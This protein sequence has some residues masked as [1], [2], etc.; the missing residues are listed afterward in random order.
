[1]FLAMGDSEAQQDRNYKRLGFYN[2]IPDRQ[3]CAG[4]YQADAME[5][6][7]LL[8]ALRKRSDQPG[9]ERETT[10]LSLQGLP[11]ALLRHDQAAFYLAN[12]S[13][14][15]HLCAVYL[16][17]VAKKSISSCQMAR[18]LGCTQRTTW[19]LA[20]QIREMWLNKSGTS[21][22]MAGEVDV[23][24]TYIGE[25]EKNKHASK[26]LRAGHGIFGKQPIIGMRERRSGRI[27][28]H[29]I[30][31]TGAAHLQG[32]LPSEVRL[33]SM[34]YMDDHKDCHEK[35][36][37]NGIE[38]LWTLLKQDCVI[39]FH[40]FSEKQMCLY[41]DKFAIRRKRRNYDAK[42]RIDQSLRDARGVI[43]HKTLTAG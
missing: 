21:G 23:D 19:Y 37:M 24:E 7:V 4:A 18:G 43:G 1:M 6:Q 36:H 12:L 35:A 38:S 17:V 25:C 41:A 10:D 9:Q 27:E 40:H 15:K 11:Q 32:A 33:G 28:V 2:A 14:C 8:P 3:G 30:D 42:A 5:R 16:M 13:P 29:P 31:G 39:T 34:I 26:K 20:Q 22:P